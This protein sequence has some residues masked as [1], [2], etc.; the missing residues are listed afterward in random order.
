MFGKKIFW[1]NFTF[2]I[3]TF[4][5]CFLHFSLLKNLFRSLKSISE[6][7][8]TSN[9]SRNIAEMI[10]ELIR[11]FNFFVKKTFLWPNFD[12]RNFDLQI[13]FLPISLLSQLYRSLKSI[14]ES[15]E[16]SNVSKNI[17]EMI[18]ELIRT[19]E[20]FVKKTF[21]WPNFDFRNFELE[22]IFIENQSSLRALHAAKHFF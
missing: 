7:L 15:L 4:K 5:Y 14:L 9:V 22:D 19:F 11:T 17:V 21:F 18:S 20:F 2:E 12:F 1:P 16:V 8:K 6:S 13:S 10:S 3:S